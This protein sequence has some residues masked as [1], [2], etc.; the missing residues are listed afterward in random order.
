[1][2]EKILDLS[3]VCVNINTSVETDK[4]RFYRIATLD[5]HM[6]CTQRKPQPRVSIELPLCTDHY[7]FAQYV[8]DRHKDETSH[9]PVR[10]NRPY[11]MDDQLAECTPQFILRNIPKIEHYYD[12]DRRLYF[13]EETF[14]VIDAFDDCTSA[15]NA[16]FDPPE[17]P[18]F[19]S[20]A[21]I[22]DFRVFLEEIFYLCPWDQIGKPRR[23]PSEES[24]WHPKYSRAQLAQYLLDAQNTLFIFSERGI[25]QIAT[26]PHEYVESANNAPKQSFGLPPGC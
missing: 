22:N 12:L 20:I 25:S 3:I 21:I 14:P 17:L 10:F 23:K 16:R 13:N 2:D 19:K 6:P 1:M 11:E 5:D 26:K 18:D 15:H 24:P 4:R 7:K 9:K 8:F